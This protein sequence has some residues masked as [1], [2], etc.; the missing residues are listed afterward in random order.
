MKLL[1]LWILLGVAGGLLACALFVWLN[2]SCLKTTR[3]KVKIGGSPKLKIVHLSDLHGKR[4]GKNNAKLIKKIVDEKPDFIAVTG[5]I[6][7]LY[8]PKNTET[9]V[10]TVN[11]LKEIA[12]VLYIAG[13][14]E[15]R[16]KGYRFLRRQ[17]KE[18][19]ATVL[20][21][22]TAEVCGITVAGLKSMPLRVTTS[23][24]AG[25]RTA[26]SGAYRSR[27]LGCTPPVRAHS[28][29]TLRACTKAAKPK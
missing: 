21:D 1:W 8:T 12:P 16:N 11:A 23:C 17:L 4:F 22:C 2:N 5:D 7:H 24:S 26:G 29:S 27:A 13:N 28:L 15:M 20:D 10:I 25:T 19:G 6:I 9:A 3:Y 14:H 18:A